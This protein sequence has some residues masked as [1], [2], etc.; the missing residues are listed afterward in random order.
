MRRRRGRA[1]GHDAFDALRVR[2]EVFQLGDAGEVHGG[3]GDGDS[4]GQEEPRETS[5]PL[6]EAEPQGPVT[7]GGRPVEGLLQERPVDVLIV[8]GVTAEEEL[9]PDKREEVIYDD[10]GPLRIDEKF[11]PRR[12]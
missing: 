10:E 2:H 6:V 4:S 8:G 7:A 11:E 9:A 5:G 12:E 3:G 1:G